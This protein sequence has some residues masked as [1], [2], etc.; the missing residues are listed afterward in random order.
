MIDQIVL[1]LIIA[2]SWQ[3]IDSPTPDTYATTQGVIN[4]IVEGINFFIG[5]SALFAVILIIV[6]GVKYITAGG[7]DE[8]IKQGSGTITNAIIGFVIV[9]IASLIVKTVISLV[10]TTPAV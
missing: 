5:F 6:G 7:D 9:L 2:Q 8:K 10:N 4:K 1:K 3:G